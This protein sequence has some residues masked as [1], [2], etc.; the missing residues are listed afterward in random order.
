M[1]GA[2]V[3]PACLDLDLALAAVDVTSRWVAEFKENP[4][5]KVA[6]RLANGL[7]PVAFAEDPYPTRGTPETAPYW[8]WYFAI[9]QELKDLIEHAF[10]TL[11]GDVRRRL[12]GTNQTSRREKK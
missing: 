7:P 1:S 12:E 4:T 2:A 11:V 3:D 6:V 5:H 8:L 10:P 9:V